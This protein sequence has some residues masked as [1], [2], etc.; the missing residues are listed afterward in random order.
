MRKAKR[1]KTSHEEIVASSAALI[2]CGNIGKAKFERV[3]VLFDSGSTKSI[4]LK[5]FVRKCRTKKDDKTKFNTRG[6]ICTTHGSCTTQ[7]SLPEFQNR[8]GTERELMVDSA[9]DRST[10]QCGMIIGA[11]TMKKLGVSV[12]CLESA[13][14]WGKNGLYGSIPLKT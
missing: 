1:V 11:D 10:T 12:M 13:A 7:F 2:N 3:R 6:G 8:K 14:D 9:T 5:H 4:I